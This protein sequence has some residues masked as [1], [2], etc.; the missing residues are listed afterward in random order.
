MT[1]Q[2]SS[3]Q[4]RADLES[5]LE[6]DLLGPWDGPEEELPAGI[7]PAERYLLGRLVP[8]PRDDGQQPPQ[9]NEDPDFAGPDLLDEDRSL[10]ADDADQ[11]EADSAPRSGAMTPS[12]FGQSFFVR[13]DVTTVLVHAS[14]GRYERTPS[15]VQT[16]EQGRPRTV[17]RRHPIGGAV[18][19]PVDVEGTGRATPYAE[20]DGVEISWTVR[21]RD[22]GRGWTRFVHILLINRMP[23][24]TATPDTHRLYQASL[25]VTALDGHAAIFAGHND[26]ALR[27]PPTIHD[28]ERFH[29]LSCCTA[30]PGA[31]PPAGAARWTPT[32]VRTRRAPGGC[33]PPAS[34]QPRSHRCCP[35][36]SAPCPA[37]SWT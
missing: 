1:A 13:A 8:R 29:L 19:V 36:T 32:C 9:A 33:A 14:W 23:I 21:H 6:R 16:T 26:P 12:A 34:P 7:S 4:V 2:T 18:D 11:R 30:A 27:T 22:L 17:W 24:P 37:S 35:V 15:E 25:T 28:G 31:T 3:V 10:D 20:Q 5:L